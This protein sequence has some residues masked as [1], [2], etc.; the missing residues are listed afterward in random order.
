MHDRPKLQ[1]T[2][3][4]SLFET[5]EHNREQHSDP[6]LL[7]SMKRYG[8][9]PS[10]PLHC[11]R[12][13]AGKLKIIRGHHRFDCAKRLGLAVWYI[14][15]SSNTDLFALEAG[16]QG[17]SLADFTYA[18]AQAGNA[19]CARVLEFKARHGLPL[20][21]AASLVGGES[22]GSANKMRAIK[23]GT[24]RVAVDQS[25]ASAVVAITDRCR[26]MGMAWATSSC[27]VAAVSKALRVPEFKV[28]VFLHRLNLHGHA[29]MRRRTT[30]DGC[31]EEI[32]TLYNYAA[33]D[34]RLPLVFRAKEV[35]KQRQETFGKTPDGGEDIA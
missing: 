34:R 2:R 31:L 33:R 5:H 13:D 20:G 26:D 30:V 21:A 8:F 14:V 19:A 1:V 18:H 10:S 27:F 29:L 4:Y 17:W 16:R 32:E 35:S 6:V 7:D 9:M 28:D 3:D 25:H 23:H 11:V 15:D 12:T 24:F 22:A